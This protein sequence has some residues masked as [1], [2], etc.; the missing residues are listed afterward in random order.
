LVA[1]TQLLR[2]TQARGGDKISEMTIQ[3]QKRLLDLITAIRQGSI[4]YVQNPLTVEHRSKGDISEFDVDYNRDPSLSGGGLRA[5]S[6]VYT[7]S[8]GGP[9][10]T[11]TTKYINLIYHLGQAT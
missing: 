4:K 7:F 6:G 1:S 10:Y 5:G 8:I 2:Q 3:N 9:V 11:I